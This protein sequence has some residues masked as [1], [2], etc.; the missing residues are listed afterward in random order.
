MD[1]KDGKALLG[2][3]LGIGLGLWST[4][5]GNVGLGLVAILMIVASVAWLGAGVL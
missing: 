3:V 5:T 4:S 2:L 1:E